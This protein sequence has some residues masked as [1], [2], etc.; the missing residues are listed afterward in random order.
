MESLDFGNSVA[1]AEQRLNKEIEDATAQKL[2][3]AEEHEE[4][5]QALE[6]YSH[7]GLRNAYKHLLLSQ[8]AVLQER[9]E[10]K[11]DDATLKQVLRT[12]LESLKV[13]EEAAEAKCCI[14]YTNPADTVLLPCEHKQF[15]EDCA[16]SVGTCPLC[17]ELVQ[18]RIPLATFSAGSGGY[19]AEI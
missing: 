18:C 11:P 19:R 14:C 13:V 6:D 9:L 10:T 4:L 2:R 3:L 12:V 17:R 8:K 16:G 5:D 15:C 1:E 7:L